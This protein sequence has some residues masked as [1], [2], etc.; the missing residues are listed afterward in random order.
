MK[1]PEYELANPGCFTESMTLDV[2][3][4]QL[5]RIPLLK[6]LCC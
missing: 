4:P 5:Y 2:V 3:E 1:T 6:I